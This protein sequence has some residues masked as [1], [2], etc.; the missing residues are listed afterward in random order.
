LIVVIE[1]Y[2]LQRQLIGKLRY[3][4]VAAAEDGASVGVNALEI[5]KKTGRGDV[6]G[7][8]E[9]RAVGDGPVGLEVQAAFVVPNGFVARWLGRRSN[10]H[11][12]EQQSHA[13][14][15]WYSGMKAQV[16]I[17][18]QRESTPERFAEK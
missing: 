2:E 11:C 15:R 13:Q 4:L 1:D 12:G 18:R 7:D 17:P 16:E 14:A 3:G 6:T 10:P 5:V 8:T 9:A